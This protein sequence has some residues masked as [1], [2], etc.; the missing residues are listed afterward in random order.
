MYK[1]ALRPD[2]VWAQENIGRDAMAPADLSLMLVYGKSG[3]LITKITRNSDGEDLALPSL[4]NGPYA[5]LFK[6][7]TL[8]PGCGL[9]STDAGLMLTCWATILRSDGTGDFVGRVVLGRL[10]D[11]PMVQLM[12][13]QVSLPFQINLTT[14]LPPDLTPWLSRSEAGPLGKRDFFT[15]HEPS[16]YHLYHPL[17]DLLGRNAGLLTL[18][19]SRDVHLQSEQL[20]SRV[21]REQIALALLV[22]A[23]LFA[24]VHILIVRRLRKLELQLLKVAENKTWDLRVDEQGKD[25]LGVL[26]DRVNKLLALIQRQWQ[27]LNALSLTDALT[28]LNNRRAFDLALAREYARER[29]NGRPLALLLI[30]A[31]QFKSYNDQYGHPMGDFALKTLAG[32]LQ[33]AIRGE[34]DLAAR[35][36]GE[37]FAILLPETDATAGL[38]I[39]DRV[40]SKLAAL[41]IAHST[42]SV[43]PY[44]TVSIGLAIARDEHLAVFM[45]RADEAL[46][47]AKK[48]GRDCVRCA[49]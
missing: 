49:Q 40:R 14:T 35:I 27:D 25:E 10:M 34:P 20:F 29:R 26:A 32:A 43:K 6:R 24:T 11:V 46:Y 13:A 3:Q 7:G 41:N 1:F 39:A 48:E 45:K 12:A 21:R 17:Q 47:Q 37:E 9:M 22:G 19:V 5:D 2:M 4:L 15:S 8:R 44:L 23:L 33:S 30:D 18:D 31:D 16:L 38:I 28:G 42:S 36:G